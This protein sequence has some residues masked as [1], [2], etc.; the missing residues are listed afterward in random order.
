MKTY[1]TVMQEIRP[2][3]AEVLGLEPEEVTPAARFFDDLGGESIDIL[4]LSFRR[5]CLWADGFGDLSFSVTLNQG[6]QHL[7]SWPEQE[8][9]SVAVPERFE[10]MFWPT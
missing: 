2:I 8:P 10:E 7:E 6:D 9:I 3:V 5:T 1:A 4:E